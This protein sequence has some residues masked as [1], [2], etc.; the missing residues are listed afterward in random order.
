MERTYDQLCGLA[1]ALDKV[2]DRWVLLIV[3]ELLT[4]PKRFSDLKR[5]LPGLA[6]NLLTDRLQAMQ[7]EGVAERHKGASGP[8]QYRL[9][10]LGAALEGP[11]HAL[12]RWGGYSLAGRKQGVASPHWL[13]VSLPAILGDEAP[14]GLHLD[15]RFEVEGFAFGLRVREGRIEFGEELGN[16]PDTLRVTADYRSLLGFF[17]GFA[18]LPALESAGKA[19]VTGPKLARARLETLVN[20]CSWY[21]NAGARVAQ[22]A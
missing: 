8:V 13:L 15:A 10:P 19:K 5:M 14:D 2:G 12:L 3:R 22:G 18:A 4:G 21:R 11:I 9:T 17:S 7:A 6:S 16:V 20:A 1:I